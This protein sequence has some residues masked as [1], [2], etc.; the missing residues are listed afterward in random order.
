MEKH[1]VQGQK[2]WIA[3]FWCWPMVSYLA[4]V[5]LTFFTFSRVVV[6]NQSLRLRKQKESFR[7]YWC[8]LG[9]VTTSHWPTAKEHLVRIK[10]L[11][12]NEFCPLP[13]PPQTHCSLG[14]KFQVLQWNPQGPPFSSHTR[15]SI[16]VRP[17]VAPSVTCLPHCLPITPQHSSCFSCCQEYL[18]I[19][20]L[21]IQLLPTPLM[22]LN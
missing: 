8:F 11:M 9:S 22:D 2:T 1:K 20:P 18:L 13:K 10:S 21:P 17:L 16:K 15:L 19:S 12:L 3:N 5:G 14:R 7:K 6:M 4:S